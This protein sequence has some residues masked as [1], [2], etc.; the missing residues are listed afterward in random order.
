MLTQTLIDPA[1][2]EKCADYF[3]ENDQIE[4]A[5]DLLATGRKYMDALELIQEHNIL[6]TEDLAEKMTLDKVDNDTEHEKIRI[7]ILERIGEIA[8]EQ[9]N[10]HLATKKFTQAGNKLR[11]MKALLKSGDT[12]K[13]DL[14]LRSSF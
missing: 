6:L 2:I 7:S 8:F 14:F 9:G 10:Y 11:A 12:E 4:K 3:V 13:I 1:L 5:V